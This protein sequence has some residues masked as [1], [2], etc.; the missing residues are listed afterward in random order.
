MKKTY[1]QPQVYVKTLMG[2][3]GIMVTSNEN[4]NITVGVDDW[5]SEDIDGSNAKR[6]ETDLDEAGQIFTH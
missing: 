4:P 5:D 6:F 1:I 2:N 3:T